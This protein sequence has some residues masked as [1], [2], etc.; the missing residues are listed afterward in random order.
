MVS[1]PPRGA[2]D[3]S[4]V[5]GVA[6]HALGYD[7]VDRVLLASRVDAGELAAVAA[8]DGHLVA[9]PS[10]VVG[11][12]ERTTGHLQQQRVVIGLATELRADG[13][14]QI[15]KHRHRLRLH[16]EAQPVAA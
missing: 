8:G 6:L 16:L 5:L 9:R 7:L 2:V 11:S 3:L 4:D 1:V 15:A 13:R 10:L 12:A 14:L